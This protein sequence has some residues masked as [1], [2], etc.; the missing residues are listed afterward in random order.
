MNH[1]RNSRPRVPSRRRI[2]EKLFNWRQIGRFFTG[3]TQAKFRYY[4]LNY[5]HLNQSFSE[6][7]EKVALLCL[8]SR[9]L[10]HRFTSCPILLLEK[11]SNSSACYCLSIP[12]VPSY[13]NNFESSSADPNFQGFSLHR[14]SRDDLLYYTFNGR[15]P[16]PHRMPFYAK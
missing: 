15:F 10:H 12:I 1:F 16:P 7:R 11:L 13:P 2:E 4:F 5:W 3:Q 8:E 6:E 14:V 9:T